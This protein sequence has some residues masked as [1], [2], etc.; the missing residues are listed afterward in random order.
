MT[1]GLAYVLRDSVR[2]EGYNREFVRQAP[3]STQEA[4]WLR[5]VLRE[6]FRLTG[7]PRAA[8]LVSQ[9]DLPLM[10]IEPVQLPCPIAQTWAAAVARLDRRDVPSFTFP[11]TL[12]S[13]GPRLM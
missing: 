8:H 9:M 6:H 2:A 7:S 5:R 10:R 3:I 4:A 1:G 12:P 11:D 13:E